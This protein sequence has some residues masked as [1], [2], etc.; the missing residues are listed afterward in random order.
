MA[1]V[2]RLEPIGQDASIETN[3]SILSGLLANNLQVQQECGG[4]GV[5][6]TCHVFIKSGMDNLSPLS[7]RE[8]RTLGVLTSCKTTSRLACQAL[9]QGEDVVVELPA[10]MYLSEIDEIEEMIGTRAPQAILHPL[11]GKVL[12]EKRKLITRSMIE[13]LSEVKG[14]ISDYL[15]TL[16]N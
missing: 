15:S 2:I 5:C 6:A 16:D 12:V 1:K 7:R 13:Q 10:G 11:S 9:V 14:E 3:R 4:R 8:Q